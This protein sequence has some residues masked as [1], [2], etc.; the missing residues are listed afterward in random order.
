[1]RRRHV[2]KLAL[3]AKK[4]RTKIPPRGVIGSK[5]LRRRRK[6]WD[7]AGKAILRG[8]IR[9]LEE[10]RQFL[11][12]VRACKP[13]SE[14]ERTNLVKWE[15]MALTKITR[16]E[17]TIAWKKGRAQREEAL[18]KMLNIKIDPETGWQVATQQL[19]ALTSMLGEFRVVLR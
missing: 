5:K 14:L 15:K 18:N 6:A 12:D 17:G 10:C 1:V 3:N 4:D 19:V 8:D 9:R 7:R 16:M 11:A 2:K 13:E